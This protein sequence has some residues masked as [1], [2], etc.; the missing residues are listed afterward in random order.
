MKLNIAEA[1]QRLPLPDLLAR[2]GLGEHAKKSARCPLHQDKSPSF[3]VFEQEGL[4]FWKCHAG[5]GEGD[6]ITFLEKHEGLSNGDAIRRFCELAGVNRIGHNSVV[7]PPPLKPK[8]DDSSKTECDLSEQWRKCLTAFTDQQ[9]EILADWRGYSPEFVAW[10]RQR[11]LIGSFKSLVAFPVHGDGGKVTAIHCRKKDGDWFYFPAGKKTHPL[12]LGNPKTADLVVVFESQWDAFGVLDKLAFHIGTPQGMAVIVTRGAGN[13]KL[14]RGL[15]K[16]G[17][18]LLAFRQ[19]DTAADKWLAEVV[20]AATVDGATVRHVITPPPHKDANDWTKAGVTAKDLMKATD[21]AAEVKSVTVTKTEPPKAN[22]RPVFSFR[23]PSEWRDYVPA[24]GMVLVGDNHIVRGNVTVIGGEPGC[25][26]SR[27]SVGLA[28]AGATGAE[29]FGYNVHRKFKTL[30]LQNENG[31]LRLKDEFAE[32]DCAALDDFCRVCDPPEYGMRFDAPDFCTALKAELDAFAPDVV[33][34][35]PWNSVALD[36]K[37]RDYLEAFRSIRAVIP[38][39]ETSPALV[40]V[41]HTRK[42][43]KTERR[44]TGRELLHELAGSYGL[45][46][47]PRT[48]FI[49]QHATP[50]TEDNRVVWTCCKANDARQLGGRSA[51]LRG[52]GLFQPVRDFDWK[53]FDMPAT[54]RAGITETDVAEVFENGRELSRKLAVEELAERTGCKPSAC[55]G[56]LTKFAKRLHERNGLLRWKT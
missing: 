48:V 14:V 36:D 27:A 10:L 38:A 46:S 45:G 31:G 4:W 44:P 30:I 23:K 15:V 55:Y 1:K 32:L 13:G 6:E 34:L 49:M 5:C 39:G 16:R 22:T 17:A 20:A 54:E 8:A 3:S 47:V 50:D 56:A 11:E 24:E 18:V 26:K 2:L 43:K 51:W 52:N 12:T 40:I 21:E 29:W 41:A 9:A 33:V 7:T 25:G 53:E 37:Q 35:D 42:P 28:L 19:N